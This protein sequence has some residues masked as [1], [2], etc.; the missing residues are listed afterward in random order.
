MQGMKTGLK[1]PM[2]SKRFMADR[3]KRVEKVEGEREGEAGKQKHILNV[4][5]ML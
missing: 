3:S 5:K 4:I 2:I 1:G